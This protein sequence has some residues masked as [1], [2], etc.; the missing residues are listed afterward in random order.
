MKKTT[1]KNE[2]EIQKHNSKRG[3]IRMDGQMGHPD[4]LE[5]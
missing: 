3:R 4:N 5:G 2:K 1:S